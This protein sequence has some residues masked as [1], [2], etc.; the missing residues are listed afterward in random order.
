M[1][2]SVNKCPGEKTISSH[3]ITHRLIDTHWYTISTL[4]RTYIGTLIDTHWYVH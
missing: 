4:I 3:Y 2:I 1:I